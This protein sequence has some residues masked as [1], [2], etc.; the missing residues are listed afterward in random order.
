MIFQDFIFYPLLSMAPLVGDGARTSAHEA[1]EVGPTFA[2]TLQLLP[3]KAQGAAQGLSICCLSGR[4]FRSMSKIWA[5][6]TVG[7][8]I[9]LLRG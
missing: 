2:M 6:M 7:S 8:V 5:N 1:T 9:R 3:P 4:R